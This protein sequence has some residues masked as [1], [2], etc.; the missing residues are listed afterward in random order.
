MS[1]YFFMVIGRVTFAVSN[2]LIPIQT[3]ILAE[4]Q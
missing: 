4:S 3:T 2:N 1:L